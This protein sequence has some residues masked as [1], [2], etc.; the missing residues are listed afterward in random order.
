MIKY[1][2]KNA[3]D[4]FEIPE[5]LMEIYRRPPESRTQ[6]NI[7]YLYQECKKLKFFQ[8]LISKNEKAQLMIRE[9]VARVEFSI[10]NKGKI[11]YAINEPII[12]MLF[13]F[14]GE[15]NIYKRK[16][17][18]KFYK[19]SFSLS[20]KSFKISKITKSL[21]QEQN[22]LI[23]DYVLYK[24]D[25][26]GKEEIKK[27]KREVQ[28]EARTK[29][30]IGF[31][32]IQDW[33]LIF[34]KTNILEKND[35]REF[36]NKTNIFKDINIL[37]LNNL[38]DIV[39]VKK[40]LKGEFLVRKGE[41]FNNI[42]LIRYGSFNIFFN[43]KIKI[44][45]EYDLN[46]LSNEKKRSQNA[47]LKYKFE[48]N[49]FDKLKYQI[50]TLFRGEFIGDIEYYLGK[51]EYA[52][53]AKCSSNDTEVIEINLQNF[54]SL[55]TKRMKIIFLNDTKNKIDYFQKRCKEI[56]KVHKNKNF[57]LKNRYKLMIINNIEEDNKD[58][59]EKM[60][61]KTKNRNQPNEKKF[62]ITVSSLTQR[63]DPFLSDTNNDALSIFFGKMNNISKKNSQSIKQNKY[64]KII[65]RVNPRKSQ[66][67]FS[68]SNS[69]K[70]TNMNTFS[71]KKEKFHKSGR[72][73]ITQKIN[74]KK[75]PKDIKFYFDIKEFQLNDNNIFRNKSHK[76]NKKLIIRNNKQIFNGLTSQ[77]TYE[78]R[79]KPN[80]P[81]IGKSFL[82]K[83]NSRDLRK[84]IN[85][86]FSYQYKNK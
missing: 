35:L 20:S 27:E 29:C 81:D 72:I 7:N 66:K 53:F 75:N 48:K 63:K 85:T 55:C 77:N 3:K 10:F 70:K 6:N 82:I 28:V 45:T 78:I 13:I 56:K 39:K 44:T 25:E 15:I 65:N 80:L 18:E 30:V 58:I 46:I 42:Y 19:G 57:G 43:T 12:N 33:N 51:E 16:I 60:E 26:Y 14:E 64:N 17:T 73:N 31:L 50:I 69:S 86:I 8:N 38:C 2:Q 74:E 62:S 34:E 23:I 83:Y 41:P 84:K 4:K 61:N 52:L 59:F 9:I 37:I 5:E 36:L 49:C 68:F 32:S 47:S 54:E 76:I 1:K 11:I 79:N 21:N 71:I 22:D 40:V 67:N 24:G